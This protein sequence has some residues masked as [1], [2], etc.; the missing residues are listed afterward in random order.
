VNPSDIIDER[1]RLERLLG[2]GGVADVWLAEDERLGRW[3]AVKLLREDFTAEHDGDLV[4]R[5]E[6]EARL[7]AGLQHPNIVGVYD[8][9]TFAGRHYLVMEYVHGY[10]LRQVLESQ[11]RL[12][13][14]DAVRYGIQIAAALQYAHTQG[15]IH[16]D[17][18][19]ENILV[20]EAGVPKVADFGVAETVSRT[21]APEQAKDI[22][23]TIAYLA[24]EVL[25]GAPA[26]PRSDVYSLAMT[27][28][29]AVAGRLPFAG[30]NAAA[31][32]GQRLAAPA[33]PL[34]AFARDASPELEAVLARALSLSPLDRYQGAA[35][36]ATA[37]QR[38]ASARPATTGAQTTRAQ[39][40]SVA[41]VP[42]VARRQPTSRVG[43]MTP[44]RRPPPPRTSG[45]VVA[46][47]IG[48]VLLALG[49]GAAGAYIIANRDDGAAG[50]LSQTPTAS[51][52]SVTATRPPETQQPTATT[53]PTATATPTL[54][55]TATKQ[56]SPTATASPTKPASPTAKASAPASATT[57]PPTPTP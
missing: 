5:F 15:V 53:P 54:S 14:V 57:P 32:A 6:R 27:L 12:R 44:A 10:S 1:Y 41:P 30:A 56:P 46:V 50:N 31:M 52:T 45:A 35:D 49:L 29:E 19:P 40:P 42:A 25:Q 20:T 47:V 18:K 39:R 3:V 51:A 8:A 4:R 16:C 33:P 37:L 43:R 9:G 24:P 26:D 34:R 11:G 2:T 28:F 13:E 7:V 55:P 38:S 17:V 36:F 23:G 22:L 48:I 21:L